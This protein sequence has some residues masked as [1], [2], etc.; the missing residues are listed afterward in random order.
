MYHLNIF[1]CSLI[2]SVLLYGLLLCGVELKHIISITENNIRFYSHTEPLFKELK[3]LN[4]HDLC[5]L[6]V[7]YNF[8][9]KC[10]T[11]NIQFILQNTDKCLF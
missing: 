7:F 4:F 11:Q 6:G 9:F 5:S 1:F 2:Q 8:I 10:T 3:K